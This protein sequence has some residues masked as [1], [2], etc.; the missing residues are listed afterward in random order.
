MN[1]DASSLGVIQAV[2]RSD[3]GRVRV[4]NEDLT[5]IDPARRWAIVADGMGGY[6]GGDIAAR[7]GVEVS[8]KELDR[9]YSAQWGV[10][11]ASRALAAAVQ[12][13][14]LAVYRAGDEDP[15]LINMGSTLLLVSPASGHLVSAHVGD[16]R[17]YRLRG[18]GLRRLTRDHTLLQDY[19]DDGTLSDEEVR[20]SGARGVLTRALGVHETV[21][22][23]TGVHDLACG[24]LLLMCSDGLTDMLHEEDIA[25]LLSGDSLDTAADALVLAANARG[26][27]DN[28][29]VVLMRIG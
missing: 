18:G 2:A 3:V 8:N 22:P 1:E 10:S 26:G 6:R 7:I 19:I 28:I 12:E 25:E 29:S 16:S 14:N 5:L 13:A 11:E 20:L 15:E 17:L 9:A 21:D 27:R 24:D 4:R 23:E